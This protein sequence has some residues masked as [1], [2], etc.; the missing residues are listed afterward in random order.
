MNCRTK[1]YPAVITCSRPE[2]IFSDEHLIKLVED[3]MGPEMGD[4]LRERLK[5][6]IFDKKQ[7]KKMLGSVREVIS[8]MEDAA[9]ELEAVIE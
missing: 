2:T 8:S 9:Y 1:I 4:F 5:M 6:A 7:L 3:A